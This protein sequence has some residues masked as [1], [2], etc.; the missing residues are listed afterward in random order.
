MIYIFVCVCLVWFSIML[1]FS[2]CTH[3]LMFLAHA[4]TYA[5][6][7][8]AIGNLQDG[9]HPDNRTLGFHI[10][11]LA[12]LLCETAHEARWRQSPS[13][14][15]ANR[16]A[17]TTRYAVILQSKVKRRLRH[18]RD[19]YDLLDNTRLFKDRAFTTIDVTNTLTINSKKYYSIAILS[20]FTLI[21]PCFQ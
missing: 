5:V 12:E 8:D 13:H 15:K 6:S 10:A 20:F 1:E 11:W 4:H 16:C 7:L 18:V 2:Q 9:A 21:Q 19:E 3:I 14:D 17:T